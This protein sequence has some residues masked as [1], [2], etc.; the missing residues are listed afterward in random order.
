MLALSHLDTGVD[1]IPPVEW[2]IL[3]IVTYL[4]TE[5][6]K[7]NV[8]LE[9]AS[10]F[11]HPIWMR[12]IVILSA[13]VEKTDDIRSRSTHAKIKEPPLKLKSMGERNCRY[14]GMY[15]PMRIRISIFKQAHKNGKVKSC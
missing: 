13:D 1:V 15:S 3:A 4:P 5:P 8:V 7:T 9:G 12:D 11:M 14:S 6:L 10:R 2:H